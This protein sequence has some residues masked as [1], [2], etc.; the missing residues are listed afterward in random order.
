MS[1]SVV[2][3]QKI[4]DDERDET[5]PMEGSNFSFSYIDS[6]VFCYILRLQFLV[7]IL[8]YKSFESFL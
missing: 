5:D 6:V 8:S 7:S 2:R 1:D 3:F 4:G